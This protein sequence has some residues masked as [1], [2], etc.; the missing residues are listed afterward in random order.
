MDVF[1]FQLQINMNYQSSAKTFIH[2]I[3]SNAPIPQPL[4]GGNGN[5]PL[6]QCILDAKKKDIL[7]QMCEQ[8]QANKIYTSLHPIQIEK[9]KYRPD[10]FVHWQFGKDTTV[11]SQ[12]N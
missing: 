12:K 4:E 10:Y 11:E 8:S 5:G 9:S 2:S 1:S 3:D 6:Y 7:I